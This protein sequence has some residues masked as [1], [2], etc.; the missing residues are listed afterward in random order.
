MVV[1]ATLALVA[2]LAAAVV[3][4]GA[5]QPAAAQVLEAPRARQGYYLSLGYHL[6]L[7]KNWEDTRDWGVW[8]GADLTLRAGQLLTRRFGLGLQ[9]HSG[10]T[11]GEGQTAS[12]FG[13]GVEAQFELVRQLTLRGG[14]GLD[15]VSIATAAGGDDKLRG[16]VG[17]GYFLGL[18]YDWFFTRRLT[19]GWAVTPVVQTRFVPGT[20]TT[21]F[22]G[23]IGV[24][25]TYWTG[26]P[27]NQLDLPP[28]EAF[29]VK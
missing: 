22:I 28:S 1:S 15:V 14:A 12:L 24:E 18:S 26:L 10:S 17:S 16:T 29:K 2:I 23:T 3:V 19:G 25:I 11:K 9:I 20:T 27:R 5:A 7:D 13:L 21:A 4:C 8:R 6:A